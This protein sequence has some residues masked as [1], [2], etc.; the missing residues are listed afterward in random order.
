MEAWLQTAWKRRSRVL[1]REQEQFKKYCITDEMD[2][3]VG[4]RR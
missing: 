3:R 1:L 4:D 2:G